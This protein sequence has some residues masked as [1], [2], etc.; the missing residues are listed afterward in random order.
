MEY[1]FS[2]GEPITSPADIAILR[3]AFPYPVPY[4]T[5]INSEGGMKVAFSRTLSLRE[6]FKNTSKRDRLAFI[7]QDL[8]ETRSFL[9]TLRSTPDDSDGSGEEGDQVFTTLGDVNFNEAK[10]VEGDQMRNLKEKKE[11]TGHAE[12]EQRSFNW[13]ISDFDGESLILQIDYNDTLVKGQLH[14]IEIAYND[15]YFLQG[16]ESKLVMP[17]GL[18]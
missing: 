4:V 6:A 7:E 15:T 16:L 17:A 12:Q 1:L 8:I 3:N 10:F 11:D 2:T 18:K 13:T 14:R 5:E 9:L